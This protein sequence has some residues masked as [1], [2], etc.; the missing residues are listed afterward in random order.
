[1][2]DK[3]NDILKIDL[4]CNGYVSY[5]HVQHNIS[6]LKRLYIKN[7][8]HD[9]IENVTVKIYSNPDFLLPVTFDQELLPRI[10][11]IK[12]DIEPQLSPLFMVEQN[13]STEGELFVEVVKE[14][15]ILASTAVEVKILAFDECNH[16]EHPRALATF[17]KRSSE[18]NKLTSLALKKTESWKTKV[19]PS[20]YINTKNG[21]RY[22]FAA[23]YSV[24]NDMGFTQSKKND[25]CQ[26]VCPHKELI[27]SK[28]ASDVEIALLLSSMLEAFNLNVVIGKIH[29]Q[30][31]VGCH[32]INDCLPEIITDDG[33]IVR[34]K[35]DSGVN[36]ISL[37]TISDLFQCIPFEKAEK[38]AY[39]LLKKFDD[40]EFFLDLKRARI[41][42][43]F[44]LPDRIKTDS[45]YDLVKSEDF[46]MEIPSQIQEFEGNIGGEK[47]I[48]RLMQW[49]RK[50]LDMDMRNNLLN[51]KISQTSVRLITP[52]IENFL[53][54][55]SDSKSF[56]LLPAPSEQGAYSDKLKN[57]FEQ[58]NYLKPF[59]DFIR[60]EYNNKKIFSVFSGK[61]FESAI[62]RIFR[63]EKSNLEETGTATLYVS[64]GFIKWSYDDSEE[65]F[66]PIYLYPAVLTRKNNGNF[67]LEINSDEAQINS[68]LLEF[69][70]QEFNI[71]IRG[72]T[73]IQIT[74][75]ATIPS[76]LNRIKKEIVLKSGWEILDEVFLSTLS[77]G[78]YLLWSD[79]KNK[80]DKFK[81]NPIINSLINNRLE[82]SYDNTISDLSS[83]EAYVS[84]DPIYLPISADSSQ[85]SA[86][87]DSLSKS[88]VLH[89]P[90]G[91]GKSQTITN[92]IANNIIR[93]RRVLFVAEKMA[94]LSVVHKRLKSIGIGDFC[95][96]LY[97]GKT[98]KNAILNQI[99]ST[100]SLAESPQATEESDGK[101]AELTLLIKKLSDELAAIHK[102]RYLGFSLYSALLSYFE[103]SNAP[104]CLRIDNLFYEKLTE[105][106][107]NEYLEILNELSLRAQECGDIEKSPFRNVGKFSYSD[108]WRKNGETI[109]DIYLMELKH[110]K[111]YA[112]AML[113]LFSIRTVS[114]T[115]AK[116]LALY[117]IS[118]A[119]NEKHI[120]SYFNNYKKFD[121]SERILNGY[122][123]SK[124]RLGILLGEYESTYGT[125]PNG[126]SCE[127]ISDAIDG[128]LSRGCR[129]SLPSTVNK[130]SRRAFFEYLLK[131]EQ[132]RLLFKHRTNDVLSLFGIND[133]TLIEPYANSI[134]A[135]YESAKNLYADFDVAVFNDCCNALVNNSNKYL[136]YYRRAYESAD[137]AKNAFEKTFYITK[138]FKNEDVGCTIDRLNNILKNID[139][140]PNWCRYQ[141]IVEKCHKSGLEFILEPLDIGEISANDVLRCF[142]KCVYYNF[143]KSE[144][145]LDEV[146]SQF[147]GLTLEDCS[148]KFK[149]L[150]EDYEKFTRKQ[151]YLKLVS[152]L[153]KT[154][155]VGE[156]NLERVILMRAE[157]N[158]MKGTTLRNL[159]ATIPN[160]LKSTSPCMLM[161]P[162]SV[163][164]FLNID[165]D[166]FDLVIF[167]EASQIPTCKA[168]GCIA[169]GEN[170]IIVGDPKQLPPTTFFHTDMKDDEHYETEDL[171]SILD[172]C[173]ALG[174]P[175]NHL[176]WHYRSNHE[177]LI[178]FS[179]ATFY[180]NS[181]L[182]FPSPN[183]K[184]SKV[185]LR[186]VDGIY[187]RGGSK[188]NKKEA[189]ELINEIINRLSTPS[190]REQ[191]IGVVTF[192]TA[193]QNYIEEK[194][195]STIH[196]KGL[197]K[198]AF[199]VEEPI[200]VK[201][202]ENVQGDERDVILFSVGYGPD[203]C[204][205]LSLNFGPIN[206]AGGYKRLNV[207][208]T[209]ARTEMMI[210]SAITGNMIDLTRTDSKGVHCLKA[211]L[212]YAERG[213]EMLA[214]NSKNVAT[215]KKISIGALIAGDLKDRGILCDYDVG[216]SDFKIDVA[217]VDPR[218]K[219]KY[220]LAILCDG[221]NAMRLK[222]VKDRVAMQF[223]ILKKLGWNTC[224]LWTANYF[225]N[226]KREISKIKEIISTLTEK[227]I[228]NR[229]TVKEIT[230]R[231]KANYKVYFAKP[232]SSPG[233]EFVADFVNEEKIKQRIR[234]IIETES[235]IEEK[236]LLERLSTIYNIAKNSKKAIGILTEYA[237]SFATFITN[238][239]DTVFYIDKANSVFRPNDTKI[240]RE[241]NQ[242]HYTEILAAI[243][244]TIETKLYVT[245][246]DLL[247]EVPLLLNCKKTKAAI[248][249]IESCVERALNE[250]EIILTVDEYLTT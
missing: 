166:K 172:D 206:Q 2:S 140:I 197:E 136:E 179:N 168:V 245:Q 187:E 216:I 12:F 148:A 209:R 74:D 107:F 77:F 62:M 61:E 19:S 65:K 8:G 45:G 242:I 150:A 241:I 181:L 17:V 184:K 156:H 51:F 141:E 103:N 88:F 100:L 249:K 119:L 33:S 224:H 3:N 40:V 86:I 183:E 49:E 175:E 68:T 204:G 185:T 199:E 219:D 143:I 211:F 21:V 43:I 195:Y 194:L 132:S 238:E 122:L 121:N 7:L 36:D 240:T 44:P 149:I 42:K 247:K 191:S 116:L 13:V 95:L 84:Q 78:N 215:S 98:D 155:T 102:K 201:N 190:L 228:L 96:E 11:T 55:I 72:L 169:R 174:L 24:L 16:Q 177:S 83:D 60:Y 93:G 14:K 97:S 112:K 46:A 170:V 246:A 186:Y 145:S 146:L 108:A 28:I 128:R 85:Y 173:L 27:Q 31:L 205:K 235:P 160:I 23:C 10:A 182:T 41:M 117:Q 188:C 159:F 106:S 22:F 243:K 101:I 230:A 226:P 47:E 29:G 87:A 1:M 234:S 80:S 125:Y 131:C 48:S 79:V 212:E 152:L 210:F 213:N 147:S 157:K 221:E 5:Y 227:K 30:W 142:K 37:V 171:E 144:L 189:D 233:A 92:I 135:L 111:Q 118:G 71:D 193:Q 104:D 70:Y 180:E 176:S 232:L 66:A 64:V 198:Y 73:N 153:P 178:A 229:K 207:A 138:Q 244:C 90:P 9:D 129:K 154:N 130:D 6:P 236:L 165:M 52:E 202:L 69:L 164:Q 126:L 248:E 89:G 20:G 63:K 163:S 105:S 217:V 113:P 208:V 222:G 167:D 200:F 94:A 56:S 4:Q 67:V 214:L 109:L 124:K 26:M 110:L 196:Q 218:D 75:I 32:L 54:A 18:T 223:R 81:Q 231:Y 203:S 35:F 192:N 139:Y 99:I 127:E 58:S 237:R 82:F 15:K 53:T 123:E 225:N 76:V 120:I 91:T 25:D 137:S 158:N 57:N 34:K 162:T 161:S 134:L 38:N 50:L 114:L 59:S 239:G 250:G 220:I 151:L 39:K 133:E 115:G